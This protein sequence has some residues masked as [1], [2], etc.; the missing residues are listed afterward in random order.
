MTVASTANTEA[1]IS[2]GGNQ[3][4]TRAIF[5]ESL[6]RLA[7]RPSVIPDVVSSLYRTPPWGYEAQPPFL[8]AVLRLTT[9]LEAPALLE[10]L[11]AV[12]T[13]LGR[14]RDA[15]RRWG[16]RPIDLDLLLFGEAS[17]CRSELTVP[18]PRL[19]QRAFVLAPLCEIDPGRSIP[20]FGPAG[21]LLAGLDTS[22]IE[23]VSGPAWAK[24]CF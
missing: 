23:V 11:Q 20:G 24:E 21:D 5:R 2:L 8:N 10:E 15:G 3:G 13:A 22:G 19:H 17:I 4:D 9:G 18:H 14:Q 12:E 1:W 7:A 16:P 6:A